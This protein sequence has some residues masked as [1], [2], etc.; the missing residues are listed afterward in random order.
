MI[1]GTTPTHIFQMPFSAET[2]KFTITYAQNDR[3]IVK[4]TEEDCDVKGNAIMITLSQED[5][6][7]FDEKK[8]VQVQLKTL[9]FE[10]NVKASNVMITTA[11]KILDEE[12]IE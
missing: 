11:G 12:V 3:E 8:A 6:L 9:D 5:T 2:L 10:G 1:R 7:L 4:K